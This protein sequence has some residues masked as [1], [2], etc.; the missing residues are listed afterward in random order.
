MTD[1]HDDDDDDGD[2]GLPDLGDTSAEDVD[3][4]ENDAPIDVRIMDDG[5]DP[6]DDSYADDVPIDVEI[7]TDHVE[8]T[9][10]GDVA[11]GMLDVSGDD[12]IHIDED[13]ESM[14]DE[15]RGHAEEGLDFGGDDSLGIDPIPTELDDGGIEGLE[16]PDGE[17]VDTEDF[18][19]L[20]GEDADD[21]AE[22]LYLGI[23]L[24]PPPPE[25]D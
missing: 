5:L 18:P 11:L 14:I 20:D 4:V 16:D 15:G 6:F 3:G 17:Q 2:L 9:A 19:P 25:T 22:E 13:G 12:G 21:D 24:D 8:P 23:D 7:Q 10:I 1:R